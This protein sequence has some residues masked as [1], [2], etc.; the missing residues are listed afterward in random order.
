MASGETVQWPFGLS[1][2]CS[3]SPLQRVQATA[4]S[5][6]GRWQGWRR[7]GLAVRCWL[8]GIVAG[9]L[10]GDDDGGGEDAS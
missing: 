4:L 6:R 1:H 5:G 10:P 7:A 3:P 8:A 2:S 9:Y